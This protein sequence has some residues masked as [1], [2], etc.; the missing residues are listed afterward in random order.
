MY[1]YACEFVLYES[2]E[3]TK[4]KTSANSKDVGLVQ[5]GQKQ[6]RMSCGELFAVCCCFHIYTR[7][8][9]GPYPYIWQHCALYIIYICYSLYGHI[10]T[11]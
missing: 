2:A 1:Y 6:E 10:R 3:T 8:D 7:I 4:E 5:K 9:I 11:I